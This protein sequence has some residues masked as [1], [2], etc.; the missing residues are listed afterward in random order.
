MRCFILFTC[1]SLFLLSNSICNNP[2]PPS[3][4]LSIPKKQTLLS[5]RHYFHKENINLKN[6]KI[7]MN[8][9]NFFQIFILSFGMITLFWIFFLH[10]CAQI[11][12]VPFNTNLNF[13]SK[14]NTTKSSQFIWKYLS[15]I[16]LGLLFIESPE[17]QIILIFICT[18]PSYF[19]AVEFT[20]KFC[21]FVSWSIPI[22]VSICIFSLAITPSAYILSLIVFQ[23]SC[24]SLTKKAPHW[25][26]IILI[27]LSNDVQLNP[28]PQFQ[29]NFFNFM[30]WNV[31]SLA[32]ENFQRVRLIEAHNSIFDYDI[33][34]I[35]ETSLNDSVNLPDPLMNDYKFVSANNPAITTYSHGGVGLFYKNSLPVII[36]NDLSFDES[37]VVELKLIWS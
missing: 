15:L 24:H 25:L 18:V 28:G 27:L 14:K 36:R 32:K 33:I 31:N 2:S 6:Q 37:I 16:A 22:A 5:H 26:S 34:S 23:I 8:F 21:K 4:Y 11:K 10:I 35:G 29:N 9:S 7:E 17:D 1:F 19:S 20:L 12:Y 3:Q 30:S 13:Y